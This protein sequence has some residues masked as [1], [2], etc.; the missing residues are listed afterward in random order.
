MSTTDRLFEIKKQID[1]AI[2]KQSEI[3]GKIQSEEERD[4]QQFGVKTIPEMEE[5]LKDI[6]K[7][8]DEEE[9]KFKKGMEK[10]ENAYVWD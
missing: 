1:E 5:K 6:G 8:I 10:L 9:A 4:E 7:E 3:A 2:P